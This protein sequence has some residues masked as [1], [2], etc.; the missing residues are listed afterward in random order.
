MKIEE[1]LIS[2]Y[3]PLPERGR[4]SLKDFNLFY[5]ENESGKTLTM[6]AIIKMLV[7]KGGSSFK[8]IDRVD[9]LPEGYVI[10][11]EDDGKKTKIKGKKSI[12][13]VLDLT[14]SEFCNLFIIRNSDLEIFKAPDFYNN[15]TDRLLGLRIND[16]KEIR[17]NLRDIGKLTPGGKFSNR[18]E[19]KFEDRMNNAKK[20]INVIELLSK[21]I[22]DEDFDRLE[23]SLISFKTKR[24]K[25]RKDLINYENVR[26]REIFEKGKA[27]LDILEEKKRELEELSVFIESEKEAWKTNE[28]NLSIY[29][30]QKKKLV[31]E[32]KE[33]TD[34]MNNIK[35]EIIKKQIEIKIPA[36]VKSKIDTDIK[37]EILEYEVK[38][39]DLVVKRETSKFF[40]LIFI[41]TS[42]LLGISLVG[43]LIS[44]YLLGYLLAGIFGTISVVFIVYKFLYIKDKGWL[45]GF[46]ERLNLELIEIGLKG[47]NF[48]DITSNIRLFEAD[49]KKKESELNNL[50]NSKNNLESA[51]NN[52][53]NTSIP[54]LEIEIKKNEDNIVALKTKSKVESIDAYKVKLGFKQECRQIFENQKAIL[55][56][57]FGFDVLD[58]ETPMSSWSNEIKKLEVYKD[59]NIELKFDE[60]TVNSFRE[61]DVELENHIK[62][63]TLTMSEINNEL[64]DI[65]INV[66]NILKPKEDYYHC[67]TSNDLI[68][69][70]EKLDD[71]LDE[72]NEKR[73]S[74]L[75][76]IEIF[77]NIETGEKEKISKLLSKKS[78]ISEYFTE[79]T[80]GLY[81]EIRFDMDSATI[82]VQ[83]KDGEFIKIEY[84]SGGAYDQLYFSIRLDL[85][86]KF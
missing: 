76:I 19:E 66:N 70:K 65:E 24:R 14:F 51:I 5:G 85:Q 53:N 34:L 33:N 12:R 84:L 45:D 40:N 54:N 75:K 38:T 31:F 18:G 41:I 23:E 73:D 42:F 17:S 1:F 15:V 16:I 50:I 79:I 82:E 59:K 60:E 56:N 30:P 43:G 71:F 58:N 74:I 35:Q 72:N 28:N 32:L 25:I 4:F 46:I 27:A 13:N 83:R 68:K 49:Y 47:D 64:S 78:S 80:N 39:G 2:D 48:E 52:L 57:L 62:S 29:N 86:K 26:K 7:G 21:K 61:K 22:K 69:F 55:K 63:I 8:Y 77:N 6:D 36:E 81:N 10:I 3:G 44:S 9:E 11:L 20:S 67:E 37:R